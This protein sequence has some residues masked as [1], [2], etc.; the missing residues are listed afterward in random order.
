MKDEKEVQIAWEI[1]IL[2]NRLNNL[3]FDHYEE[4]FSDIWLKE[5]DEE[6]LFLQ[7]L[8][9]PSSQET[10]N[11]DGEETPF[12]FPALRAQPTTNPRP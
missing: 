10:R 4:E 11:P 9:S 6:D 8:E 2:I 7:P 5:G 3:L 1:W 12:A